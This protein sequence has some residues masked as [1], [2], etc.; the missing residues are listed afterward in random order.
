MEPAHG[1]LRLEQPTNSDHLLME[2]AAKLYGRIVEKQYPIR[3]LNITCNQVVEEGCEQC[4][5]FV[6]QRESVRTKR[7]Q[8]AVL[9][10]KR[11]YGKNAILKGMSLEEGATARERNRQ[12]GGHK[13]GE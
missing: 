2:A 13:S 6:D 12:I 10:I 9:D 8:L 7:L 11:K 1:S 5:L 3:R 4:S